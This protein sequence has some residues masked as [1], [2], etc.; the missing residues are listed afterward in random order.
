[1]SES[2][3]ENASILT[4]LSSAQRA[5][6]KQQLRAGPKFPSQIVV[7]GLNPLNPHHR[8]LVVRYFAELTDAGQARMVTAEQRVDHHGRRT[9]QRPE[10]L[11]W[12]LVEEQKK[13]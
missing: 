2:E 10:P 8:E 7:E 9:D 6:I 5:S 12:Q 4:S 11:G 13:Q 3:T 1:M